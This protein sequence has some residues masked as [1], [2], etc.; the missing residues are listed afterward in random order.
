MFFQKE[1]RLIL[2]VRLSLLDGA[3]RLRLTDT[4]HHLLIIKM[5]EIS[6]T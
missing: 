4:N 5:S 2:N 6:L 3:T 1:S